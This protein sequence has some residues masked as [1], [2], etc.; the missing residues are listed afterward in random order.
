ML[1]DRVLELSSLTRL[2]AVLA[3]SSVWQVIGA[4]VAI[5]SLAVLGDYARMLWLRSKM[6]SNPSVMSR[7]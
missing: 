3:G 4:V 2:Q 5:I 7:W 1:S 6:V